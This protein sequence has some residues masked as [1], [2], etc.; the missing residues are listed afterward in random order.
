MFYGRLVFYNGLE[1]RRINR[2]AKFIADCMRRLI[3]TESEQRC[4]RVRERENRRDRDRDI[5]KV[6]KPQHSGSNSTT[7]YIKSNIEQLYL[8]GNFSFIKYSLV[9]PFHNSLFVP[10]IH[11][12]AVN[13]RG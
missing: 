1:T 8:Y 5:E 9:F 10:Q 3:D 4:E 6:N 12:G 7:E 13:K 2:K 11:S